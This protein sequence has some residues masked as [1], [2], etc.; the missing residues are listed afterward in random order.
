MARFLVIALFVVAIGITA[1]SASPTTQNSSAWEYARL[2]REDSRDHKQY[3]LSWREPGDGFVALQ[4]TPWAVIEKMGGKP[5]RDEDS[6]IDLLCF[7]GS[8][9]W[10]L[11]GVE[12]EVSDTRRAET[13]F[14][15]RSK[16]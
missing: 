11:A 2:L 5:D 3:S 14:F 13:F 10:R 4:S 12:V 6:M 7:L 15:E 1:Y 9:G 16:R 8:R